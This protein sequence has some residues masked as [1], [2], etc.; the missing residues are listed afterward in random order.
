VSTEGRG[1]LSEEFY[2]TLEKIMDKVK[3]KS[4]Y[5]VDRRNAR[6]SIK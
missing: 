1:Q 5:N 2:D 6:K 3:K 4:L